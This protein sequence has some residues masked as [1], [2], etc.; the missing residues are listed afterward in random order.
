MR[1]TRIWYAGLVLLIVVERLAELALSARHAR[2]LRARG[3]VEHGAGHYPVMVLLHTALFVAAPAEVFLAGRAFHP[4]LGPPMVVLL[5]GT[6]LLRYW[7]IATL[8]DR[9]CTRVIVPPGEPPIAAG[10]YRYLR[11]PNYLAV[12]VEV[13]SLALVHTAW[14]TAL[15]LGV[16]N[17][18]LLRTRIRVE[19]AALG[20]PAFSDRNDGRAAATGGGG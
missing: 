3:G 6:L 2:R 8:G 4:W 12:A 14:L 13:P 1:D 11:H 7:V 10:P 17:L 16:L 19:D 18:V 20:R 9:W 15:V 5:I